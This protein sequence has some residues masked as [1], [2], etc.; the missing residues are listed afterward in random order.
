[1]ARRRNWAGRVGGGSEM[2][3]IIEI[4]I[5]LPTRGQA[6]EANNPARRGT[7]P[8]RGRVAPFDGPASRGSASG[9]GA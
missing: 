7:N 4:F 2:A 3:R 9:A 5:D 8:A 6:P 1:M